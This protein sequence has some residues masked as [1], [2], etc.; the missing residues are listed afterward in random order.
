MT[1]LFGQKTDFLEILVT[2]KA[3][4][5]ALPVNKKDPTKPCYFGL[6]AKR[7]K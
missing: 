2:F 4:E 7:G 1:N 3:L 6:V 5:V